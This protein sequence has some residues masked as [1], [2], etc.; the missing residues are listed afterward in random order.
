MFL[1]FLHCLVEIFLRLERRFEQPFLRPAL[2]AAVRMP[3]ALFVTK[4]QD[5]FLRPS[6]VGA[7][8]GKIR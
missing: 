8:S 4:I 5:S 3:I 6:C 7:H 1:K 2:D